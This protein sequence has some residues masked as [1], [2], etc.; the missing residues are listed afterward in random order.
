MSSLET[1]DIFRGALNHLRDRLF[2]HLR[3]FGEIRA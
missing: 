3:D 1:T 2:E